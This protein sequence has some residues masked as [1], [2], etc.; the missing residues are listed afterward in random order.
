MVVA[1]S[2]L[3]YENASKPLM[4][5]ILALS[6]RERGL[7]G[8]PTFFQSS[9]VVATSTLKYKN[10]RKPLMALTL[11]LSHRRGDYRNSYFLTND[12]LG[13]PAFVSISL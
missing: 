5:L 11:A 4:A 7:N 13:R 12:S 9:T 8:I 3:K 6:Q 1:T 10:T 2:T